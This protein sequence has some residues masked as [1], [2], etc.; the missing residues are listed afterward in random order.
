MVEY[1]KYRVKS[2][3]KPK[4]VKTENSCCLICKKEINK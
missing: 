4:W 1:D 2:K 3:E